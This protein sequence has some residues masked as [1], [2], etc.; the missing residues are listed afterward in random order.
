VARH[1]CARGLVAPSHCRLATCLLV[2]SS[3]EGRDLYMHVGIN[4]Y[5]DC[6]RT[7]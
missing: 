4:L 2:N 1:A 5:I 6:M 3:P 7:V